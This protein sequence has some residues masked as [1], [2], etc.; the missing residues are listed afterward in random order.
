MIVR[1]RVVALVAAVAVA[2]TL[3]FP[4][5]A[6][7]LFAGPTD[8][9]SS[10]VQL[11]P[12]SE[13]ATLEDGELAVDLSA[14]NADVAGRG[15]N[16][17]AVTGISDVF[18]VKYTGSRYARVWLSHDAE[19][20]TLYANGRPI[21]SLANGVRLAPNETVSVGIRVNTTGESTPDAILNDVTVHARVAEPN[22]VD[23]DEDFSTSS[24]DGDVVRTRVLS[25]TS[26]IFTALGGAADEM[27][28]FD[29]QR[30]PIDQSG[31]ETLTL[32][33]LR[34][35]SSEG[36]LS[37]TARAVDA[38]EAPDLG[39]G[40]SPLGGVR[41]TVE[42]GTVE[43]ATLRFSASA[44]YL[45]SRG[46]TASDL[47]VF[48]ESDGA[49][50]ALDVTMTDR[51]DGRV[52]F[53]AETSGFS[54]VWVAAERPSIGVTDASISPTSVEPNESTTVTATVTNDGLARGGLTIPVRVGD[55]AVAEL[56]VDLAPGETET[57]T[58][59]VS[60]STPGEYRV[61]VGERPAATLDVESVGN[62]SAA[63]SADSTSRPDA[64]EPPSTPTRE[65]SGFDL[66]RIAGLVALAVLVVATVTLVRRRLA[67]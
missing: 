29:A 34:V 11:A 15:V 9:V 27:V 62:T 13:Y 18:R 2:G 56:V 39:V 31:G 55:R 26:R 60:V 30:L 66:G 53:E 7:V 51:R 35:E 14:G 28:R 67:P 40:A 3:V 21:E 10:N 5:G 25:E 8:A 47:A 45:E 23:A 54:T 6:A 32:D 63:N 59:P 41:V 49:V 16:P 46:I 48:H 22:D 65:R 1:R 50:R 64:T 61:V 19:G 38:D 17:D 52:F 20:V 33:E 4:S 24:F 44:A 36:S 58:V 12:S 43:T 37:L 42:T 57:L